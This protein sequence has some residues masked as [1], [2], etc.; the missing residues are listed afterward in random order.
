MHA[1]EKSTEILFT[2][3]I[4]AII[5]NK[6]RFYLNWMEQGQ[7]NLTKDKSRMATKIDKA[8]FMRVFREIYK[9]NEGALVLMQAVLDHLYAMKA[10][11]FKKTK[12]ESMI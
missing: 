7:S 8:S 1:L 4:R 10:S 11:N 2:P 6:F 5:E 9:D 12:H 3:K